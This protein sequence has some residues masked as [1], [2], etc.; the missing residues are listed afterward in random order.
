LL[1]LSRLRRNKHSNYKLQNHFNKYGES[2]L[3]F[4]VLLGCPREDLIKIEQYFI[5]SYKPHFNIALFA[6]SPNLGS[7]MSD[8]HKKKISDSLKGKPANN[9]GIPPSIET[10]LKISNS[11]KGRIKSEE[12]CKN[13]SKGQI[14][15]KRPKTEEQKKKISERQIGGKRSEETKKR[16]S[17]SM[18]GNKN[19]VG[20]KLTDKHKKAVSEGMKRVWKERRTA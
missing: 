12:E 18:M 11:L 9:K 10:R 7:K 3:Q 1:H 4:S 14:G 6:G 17:K 15:I 13:I 19:N 8:E 16:M 5:D 20:H 2:D